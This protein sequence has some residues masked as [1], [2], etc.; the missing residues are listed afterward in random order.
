MPNPER[1]IID[2]NYTK[3]D[4]EI[5]PQGDALIVS[6]EVF[7]VLSLL[8]GWN[9]AANKWKPLQSDSQ[10]RLLTSTGSSQSD[11]PTTSKATVTSSSSVVLSA[12]EDRLALAL[13]NASSN[14]IYFNLGDDAAT[15]NSF[16]IPPS[17]FYYTSLY[18][19]EVNAIC[20]SGSGDLH[21][22]EFA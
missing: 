8:F 19:G 1:V 2:P 18:A 10:G 6:P 16:P 11:T 9:D 7:N 21:I 22:Q 12:N 13:Y 15:A 14:I 20:P 4:L 5:T 3:L 17:G